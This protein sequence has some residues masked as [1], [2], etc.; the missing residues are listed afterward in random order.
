MKNEKHFSFQSSTGRP[1][2]FYF[3]TSF[4]GCRSHIPYSHLQYSFSP[5]QIVL[6]NH[7]Q[8]SNVCRPIP[9]RA[10]ALSIAWIS[11]EFSNWILNFTDGI[12]AP[13]SI[14][15]E[16]MSECVIQNIITV[17]LYEAK[18]MP[19]AKCTKSTMFHCFAIYF[20]FVHLCMRSNYFWHENQ[21]NCCQSLA[22]RR[23]C[24]CICIFIFIFVLVILGKLIKIWIHLFKIEHSKNWSNRFRDSL[25]NWCKQMLF[26]V[27]NAQ[28]YNESNANG[29]VNHLE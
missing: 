4:T 26:D 6:S 3:R 20:K 29:F 28:I 1:F 23:H 19:G 2:K 14:A 12:I 15:G 17:S 13:P 25:N 16:F 8:F 27:F 7:F 18:S 5:F 22:V 21:S 24:A 11:I 9:I 10:A